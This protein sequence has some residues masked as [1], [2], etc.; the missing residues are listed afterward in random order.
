MHAWDIQVV[1]DL[2]E[3]VKAGS[4][5]TRGKCL[6]IGSLLGVDTVGLSAGG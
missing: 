1:S 2:G 6:V 5:K 3:F 4:N